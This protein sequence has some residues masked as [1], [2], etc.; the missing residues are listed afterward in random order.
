MLNKVWNLIIGYF[1]FFM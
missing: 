1:R